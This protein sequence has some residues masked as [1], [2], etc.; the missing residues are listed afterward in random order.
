MNDGTTSDAGQQILVAVAPDALALGVDAPGLRDLTYDWRAKPGSADNRRR[1][2][3]AYEVVPL[4]QALQ[5]SYATE[6]HAVGYVVHGPDGAPL[7]RQPRIN[8]DGL[9]WL[10]A[11]GFSVHTQVLFV[12]LDNPKAFDER[13]GKRDKRPWDEDLLIEFQER[14]RLTQVARGAGWYFS[15][16]GARLV[17]T[18]SE[19]ITDPYAVDRALAAL[20]A[21]LADEGFHPD[22]Q[23]CRWLWHYRLPHIV[24]RDGRRAV[25]GVTLPEFAID[26]APLLVDHRPT[27]HDGTRQVR[28]RC[29]KPTAFADALP[30]DWEAVVAI[31]ADGVRRDDPES[32][33]RLSLLLAGALCH[34]QV[35]F[36]LVPTL[37]MRVRMAFA[38]PSARGYDYH[39]QLAAERVE[40]WCVG[41]A[42]A[43]PLSLTREFPETG[44]AL[45]RALHAQAIDARRAAAVAALAPTIRPIDKVAWDLQDFIQFAATGVALLSCGTGVGKSH[46]AR[47]AA[48]ERA[49]SQ[50][51]VPW[52][53]GARDED[54]KLIRRPRAPE[55]TTT[56]ITV[57]TNELA[58][59]YVR[60]LREDFGIEAKR[61]FSP[62]TLRNDDGSPVCVYHESAR[63]LLAAG[64]NARVELCEGR[65]QRPCD[66]Q[67]AC[68]AYRGAE[69][70]DDARVV[71]APHALMA[72]AAHAAGTGGLLV[73]DE[74]PP[75]LETLTFGEGEL[76]EAIASSAL[77]DPYRLALTPL[78]EALAGFL[79]HAEIETKYTLAEAVTKGVEYVAA[80]KMRAAL[81]G[82]QVHCTADPT[83]DIIRCAKLARVTPLGHVDHA[84]PLF[85]RAEIARAKRQPAHAEALAKVAKV[86]DAVRQAAIYD[87]N[88][89]VWLVPKGIYR[90]LVVKFPNAQFVS[91]LR[92][93]GATVLA[94]A[95]MHVTKP[96]V[97]HFVGAEPVE[98]AFN[99]LD[100]APIRRTILRCKANKKKWFEDG[101]PMLAPQSGLVRA[102][103]RMLAWLQSEPTERVGLITW[104]SV[105]RL[106]TTS[107]DNSTDEA[108][109]RWVY[110]WGYRPEVLDAGIATLR[111]LLSPLA[112]RLHLGHY[113]GIRGLNRFLEADLDALVTFG[114][115]WTDIGECQ[116]DLQYLEGV[117][118][119]VD[120]AS[121]LCA[122]ELGQAHGRLR[123]PRRRRP[124]RVLHVGNVRPDAVGWIVGEVTETHLDAD[125]NTVVSV[126]SAQ[127]LTGEIGRIGLSQRK[128]AAKLG[129]DEKTI[130]RWL[131]GDTAIPTWLKDALE[132]IR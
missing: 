121:G 117:E 57:P 89:A 50:P 3:D 15:P 22:E 71:I 33:H 16:R 25:T 7:A 131:R 14:M 95:H 110:D 35:P 76:R 42:V 4:D 98:R 101:L 17:F 83:G 72:Q 40:R 56:A 29:A 128:I 27:S 104:L 114:D 46:A 103:R 127:D 54:D 78:F 108:K 47:A 113:G 92:R 48:A 102:M 70:P 5:T 90:N 122:A 45:Q 24:R 38:R 10:L 63:T 85:L 62:V 124:A 130:R 41:G 91:M 26:T 18:L 77:Y 119:L 30:P 34:E 36:E 69:G 58:R 111:P 100:G 68:R 97:T 51:Q 31:I 80:P 87:T 43:S 120:Y 23:C 44:A 8:K 11:Q 74:P 126:F 28:P 107:L 116:R 66:F 21:A 82:A 106:I 1:V 112:G 59:E 20:H 129:V 9:P 61:L 60:K 65:G 12:D 73:V 125:E 55:G 88:A 94:D 75:L 64:I 49:L 86:C 123:E 53:P 39:R 99:A 67:D 79:D 52:Q 132:K 32:T 37:V 19:A 6:A 118:G 109:E 105:E 115:P 96:I 81:E 93:P 2:V 13:T 84:G